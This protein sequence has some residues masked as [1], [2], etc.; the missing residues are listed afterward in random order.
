MILSLLF[1]LPVRFSEVVMIYTKEEF[2]KRLAEL[3][4]S[5]GLSELCASH[6]DKLYTIC[7]QLDLKSK[8]FNLTAITEP[9][10]VLKKHIIDC[11]F[12]AKTVKALSKGKGTLLDV[13]SGA[14][15]P[16]LPIAAVLPEVSVTA[17]D[18]TAKKTVYMNETAALAGIGNFNA[19]NARA[20]EAARGKMGEAFD[21]VSARAVAR[22]NVLL[23]LCVPFL[24]VG[25]YFVSMKGAAADEEM[26][27]AAAATKKLGAVFVEKVQY[28]LPA[29]CD[30]RYLLVYKKVE[31][32]PDIYPRNFSQISKKP[33]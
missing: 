12:A 24:K 21:I 33:L 27:E 15:F 17:M 32:T 10:E 5:S 28:S 29:L 8:Q 2:S 13:G 6:E 30:E 22:L 23:E 14:G 19:V 18:A 11:V 26:K 20:E 7:T 16:S 1:P 31:K 4:G 25:G 9:E 3:A